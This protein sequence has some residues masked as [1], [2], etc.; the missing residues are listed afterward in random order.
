MPYKDVEKQKAAQRRYYEENKDKY[1]QG[2]R[3][4]RRLTRKYVIEI[5]TK[6]V[7]ADCKIDYPHYILQFDHV[8]GTKLGDVNRIAHDGLMEKLIEEIA[9]CEIVCGNCHAHRTWMR[10]KNNPRSVV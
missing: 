5:K 1:A 6:A 9:K 4:R 7:C 8:T 10:S 3:D 2:V